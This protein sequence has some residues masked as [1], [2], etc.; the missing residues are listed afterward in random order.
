MN[1]L[2]LKIEREYFQYFVILGWISCWISLSFNPENFE[3]N[4]LKENLSFIEI[5]NFLR[6]FLQLIYFPIILL[7]SFFVFKKNIFKKSNLP[8]ILL[9]LFFVT[10]FI[11]IFLTENLIINLICH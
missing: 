6:G 1:I 9:F 4:Y 11:G 7:M 8:L 2:K 5:L 3:I 10:Q